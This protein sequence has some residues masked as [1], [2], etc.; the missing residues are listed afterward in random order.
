MLPPGVAF[1][2]QLESAVLIDCNYLG[3][4]PFLLATAVIKNFGIGD[5]SSTCVLCHL[6]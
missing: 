2:I 5:V 4:D 1:A 3:C 6:R